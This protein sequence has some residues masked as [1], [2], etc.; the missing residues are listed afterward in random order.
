MTARPPDAEVT[1]GTVAYFE[2]VGHRYG[3]VT[4][5]E[6]VTCAL[7]AGTVTALIGPNGSGKTTL[8]R[9]VAGL[10]AP[11]RGRVERPPRERPVGYLP[12]DPD[13]RPV[14]SVEETLQFYADLLEGDVDVEAALDQV[15]L[16]AA[17]GRR[18]DALSG[19]M[20]RL[21]GL[22]QAL[23]GDPP[24]VLLDEPTGDLDPLMTEHILEVTA[25]LARSGTAVLFATHD[26]AGATMADTVLVLDRGTVVASGSPGDLLDQTGS[27]TL[28][29][30]FAALVGEGELSVRVGTGE[31]G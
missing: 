16:I 13:F 21:L 19:G 8:L 25:D 11:F 29:A 6:G 28:A 26:L 2:N 14:F 30:A 1:P 7:E 23:L 9:I 20:R 12:Q 27:E 3:D 4:V 22:A 15:G 10:L 17:R 31:A 18:V 5:L 24:V